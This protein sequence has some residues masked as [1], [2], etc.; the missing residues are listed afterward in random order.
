MTFST[1]PNN[2][3]TF[4]D[5]AHALLRDL[6]KILE[7]GLGRRREDGGKLETSAIGMKRRCAG[8]SIFA[9]GVEKNTGGTEKESPLTS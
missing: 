8:L 4:P 3:G 9:V 1:T 2:Q 6:F 7:S 5:E